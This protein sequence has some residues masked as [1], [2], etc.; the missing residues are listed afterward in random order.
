[1][2]FTYRLVIL[3]VANFICNELSF[4]QGK[5]FY[6]CFICF[7]RMNYT[8]VLLTSDER[9]YLSD[10]QLFEQ[11]SLCYYHINNISVYRLLSI[12]MALL[13][14]LVSGSFICPMYFEKAS[15]IMFT[16]LHKDLMSGTPFSWNLMN[17]FTWVICK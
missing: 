7:K 6:L 11:I 15:L 3:C 13:H 5:S 2:Y 9:L 16:F 14:Y 10:E 12:F 1:M 8:F 4:F 17:K